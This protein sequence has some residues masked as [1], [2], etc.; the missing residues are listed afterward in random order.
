MVGRPWWWRWRDIY[1]LDIVPINLW[2]GVKTVAVAEESEAH[3]SFWNFSGSPGAY[4][5]VQGMLDAYDLEPLQVVDM[6]ND[7]DPDLVG[8]DALTGYTTAIWNG[9]SFTSTTSQVVYP[10]P[11]IFGDWDGT[12]SVDG[13]F[14]Q[15]QN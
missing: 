1:A 8:N 9:S 6:D 13:Q 10:T 15:F 12:G 2:S 4:A 3:V 7:G 5:W 14:G 11:P